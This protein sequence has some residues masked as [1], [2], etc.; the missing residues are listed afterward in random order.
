V[1]GLRS[2][3][4]D[5]LPTWLVPG[6]SEQMAQGPDISLTMSDNETSKYRTSILCSIYTIITNLMH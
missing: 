5:S 3:T 6:S 2:S 4:S 1:S